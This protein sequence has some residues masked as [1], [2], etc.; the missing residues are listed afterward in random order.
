MTKKLII[1]L[2]WFMGIAIIGG[3]VLSKY[4]K[5][6]IKYQQET[7]EVQKDFK[8]SLENQVEYVKSINEAFGKT[9]EMERPEKK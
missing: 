6:V 3:W 2:L 5:L 8:K 7:I 1:M 9:V 4:R